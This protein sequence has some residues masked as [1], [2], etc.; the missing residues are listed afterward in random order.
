M[1][2]VRLVPLLAVG[3]VVSLGGVGCRKNLDK[4]TNIP[5]QPPSRPGDTGAGTPL[6]SGTPLDTG[7]GTGAGVVG[8]P[9]GT[10]EGI[11]ASERNFDNMDQNR[12]V[13]SADT[14]HFEFDKSNVRSADVPKLES[15]AQRMKGEFKG[16]YLRIEGY[17]DERGTEEYNRSLGDRRAQSAREFLAKLGVNP[18]DV[19][20]ITFGEEKP[21]DPAHNE[22]A[23]AKNRRCEFV[24][25]TPK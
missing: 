7:T 2:L 23:W 21:A 4:V 24:L 8:T 22:A 12:E 18:E 17:C 15:I 16:K 10:G 11:K 13:F 25:L 9:G 20:T 19:Q 3:L 1:K 5:G 6:G 14:I